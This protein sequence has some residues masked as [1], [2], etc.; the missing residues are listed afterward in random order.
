MEQLH[1]IDYPRTHGIRYTSKCK[2][3]AKQKKTQMLYKSAVFIVIVFD[4][5]KSYTNVS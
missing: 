4:K 1:I 5:P 2:Q 3:P